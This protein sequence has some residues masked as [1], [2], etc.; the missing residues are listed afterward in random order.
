MRYYLISLFLT[1]S[2]CNVE[3]VDAVDSE[4]PP[5]YR[6]QFLGNSGHC[7]DDDI[8]SLPLRVFPYGKNTMKFNYKYQRVKNSDD[9]DMTIIKIP[10]GP[11]SSEIGS[12]GYFP[13][14]V[15]V[16]NIDPR[17]TGCNEKHP[18]V[19]PD[20]AIN[21]EDSAEDIVSVI[22]KLNL[23]D[24]IIYGISYGTVLAT[25]VA[26][27]IE[28]RNLERPKAII[29]DSVLSRAYKDAKEV[30]SPFLEKWKFASETYLQI[31][32]VKQMG[33]GDS[34]VSLSPWEWGNLIRKNLMYG[35]YD[36]FKEFDVSIS[37][38]KKDRES[39]VWK[40]RKD[41]EAY[42]RRKNFNRR[43]NRLI[44]GKELF[45]GEQAFVI[46]NGTLIQ[47][48]MKTKVTKPYHSK[49]WQI[50]SPIYY[51]NGKND[52][53][54]FPD[55]AHDH[56]RHQGRKDN[57]F[58]YFIEDIFHGV[59]G[60]ISMGNEGE[61]GIRI[62]E[63]IVLELDI[64]DTLGDCGFVVTNAPTPQKSRLP[65]NQIIVPGKAL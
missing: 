56:Y 54:T 18:M 42:S 31:E 65:A 58:P 29:L 38:S 24:Y 10:G 15:N 19:L 17:G 47:N 25:I 46:E 6:P 30:I 62:L 55:L 57:K 36:T 32:T 43:I 22:E 61:C 21:S 1:I 9:N 4:D 49:R 64:L 52:P 2:S 35:P 33:S 26:S 20:N 28:Q 12:R 7:N 37:H 34:P 23:T 3:F 16:I 44:A 63:E 45:P 51:L 48:S 5:P 14:T 50:D 60:K 39:F 41:L 27:K 59:W 8:F 53:V 13:A 11:G 40:S